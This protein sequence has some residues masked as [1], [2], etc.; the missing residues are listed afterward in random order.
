MILSSLRLPV[1][2]GYRIIEQIYSSKQ[3]LVY[4]AVREADQK[5]V[6]IK[7]MRNE[8]PTSQEIVQFRNQYFLSKN[9]NT[10]TIVKPY[11]LEKYHKSYA[12]VMEDFGGM[13][14][15]KQIKNC[16][17]DNIGDNY[18]FLHNFLDIAI[19][20]TSALDELH[21]NQIIHKDI[22]PDN[23]LIN[24]DTKEVK[25]IDFSISTILP[26]EVQF[27]IN[28]DVLEGTLA[29]ISP[30]QTGRMNK[31]IDYRTDYYSL[32]ITLFELLTGQLPFNNDNP[33]GLI[34]SHISEQPPVEKII[35]LNIPLIISEL[36]CK[37]MEKNPEDRY[38]SS[39]GLKHDLELCQ[40]NLKTNKRIGHFE[41]ATKDISDRFSIPDTLYGRQVE[42]KK[43]LDAFNRVINPPQH[44]LVRE[45]EAR[46]GVELMLVKG[47]SG[48]GKTAVVNEIHK[49]IL[50][51]K[52]YFIKC[53]FNQLQQSIPFLGWIQALNDLIEQLL[54][55][56]NEQIKQWKADILSA[57]GDQAQVM[58]DLIPKL[59]LI[60]GLQPKAAKL[61]GVEAQNRLELLFQKLIRTFAIRKH[62]LVIFLDDL[63]WADAASLNFIRLLMCENSTVNNSPT[64]ENV[65]NIQMPN[66]DIEKRHEYDDA[67]LLIGSYRNNE[68]DST[69][70]L[71]LTIE[72]IKKTNVNISDINLTCLNQSDLAFLISDT[73]KCEVNSVIS[74]TEVV[75][76]KTKGNPFFIHQFIN[77]LYKDKVIKFNYDIG[78]WECDVADVRKSA[79]TDDVVEFMTLQIKKL[80][81]YTQKL[82]KIA[83]CIG[84][85]FDL[86]TLS[87]MSQKSE[88]ATITHLWDSVLQGLVLPVDKKLILSNAENKT[89]ELIIDSEDEKELPLGH[90]NA[91]HFKFIHD[92][93]QQAAYSQIP[94]SEKQKIHL[95]LG[96]KLLEK[97]SAQ[98]W[99]EDIFETANQFNKAL[100]L[101]SLQQERYELA[102]MNLLAGQKAISSTAYQE[103]L[104]YLTTGRKLLALDTWSK[105]YQ[106]SLSLHE[107]LAEVTY[108]TGDFEASEEFVEVVIVKAKTLLEKVKVYEIRIQ[109]YT[110]QN[111]LIEAINIAREVLKLFGVNF[112]EKPNQEDIYKGLE[113]TTAIIGDKT[114]EELAN[115]PSISCE[116]KLAIMRIAS[117]MIPPAYIADQLLFPM[118]I[119][120]QVN[121]TVKYGNG[122][123]SA[124]CYAC[125][126][127]ILNSIM[128]D[129][130]SGDKFGKLALKLVDKLN[131]KD[132]KSKT[133]Y[134]LGSFI[135][136]RKSHIKSTLPVLID[137]YKSGIEVG[138]L[139][140]VGY[141]AKEICKHN[142]FIGQELTLLEK[143]TKA[144][145]SSLESIKQSTT[146]NYC[147]IFL[148]SVIHLQ[149]KNENCYSLSG[150]DCNENQL[151]DAMIEAKDISGLHYL[152]L[153]KFILCYWFGEYQQAKENAE[154]VRLYLAGGAGFVTIP[155][156]YFYESLTVLALSLDQEFEH[157]NLLTLVT[158]N[159]IQLKK[160]AHHAPMNYLH[161][162]YL[163]EAERYRVIG[164]Y[165]EAIDF[166]ERAITIAKENEY[167]H[168]EALANEL[169]AKF[170]LKWGKH[171]I[172]K[173]YL[174]DA[175]YGYINWG[176]KAKV[177]DLQK[178]YPQLLGH[179]F[180]HEDNHVNPDDTN[181]GTKATSISEISRYES[182]SGSNTNI[183]T[184]LDL[185]SV[186][187]ASQA[188]SER[189]KFDELLSTLMEV[190]MENAGASKCALIL[191]KTADFD[192]ELTAIS[193]NH[194]ISSIFTELPSIPLDSSNKVPVRLINYVKRTK[195]TIVIDDANVENILAADS[196][197]L[198][199][200]PKSILCMAI[201]NQGKLFG[202]IYLENKLTSGV[203]TR[204]LI[205]FINLIINQAAIS[206]KN[207]IL[208]NNLVE[209]KED[210][211]NYNQSLEEK[212]A[213]RTQEINDK[214]QRL[215][216]ALKELQNTQ[217]QLIQTEKM[218][219][220][221]Q[222]I[223]GIAHE[224]NN[225]INFIHGNISHANKYV[226]DLLEMIAIYK[227]EFTED[228][229]IVTEKSTE[230]DL[231]FIVEDLPKILNSI[232]VGT[233]RIRDIILGLRNFSRLDEAEMKS[234][235]IHE[236]I[237]NTLMILQ[238]RFKSKDNCPEIQLIKEY[239]HLPEIS[240]YPS[241]LNQVFMNILNNA[242]DALEE[243]QRKV[244][245]TKNPIISIST[246]LIDSN[247]LRISIGDNGFGMEPKVKQKIFDPF[248]TTKPVG[249]G[250]GLGLSISYQIIVKKHK[251]QLICNSKVG[252][253]TKFVIDLPT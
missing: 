72:E 164:K 17:F 186:I 182:I 97:T 253:G 228:N 26:K 180:L 61:S 212:V 82:L 90:R 10:S 195:E 142:Y 193:C 23:I 32:G 237:E 229:C 226:E 174:D 240:C 241:Q 21:R 233:S 248:F 29:Y 40:R 130:E 2:S 197:I 232:E 159:Q 224:I 215:K 68:V 143:Q 71:S 223:A 242:I 85:Q 144:Y 27:L 157:E 98:S 28:P 75:F 207:A 46:K 8:Y 81:S 76:A 102:R 217:S 19:K 12:F 148:Q 218:S 123:L 86:E 166:Y 57:L 51:E 151:L 43:L 209:S 89:A 234:V 196:Y 187:K 39:L 118:I 34:Y 227:Q 96:K 243:S 133:F 147:R 3:T 129:I 30:E 60:I 145:I 177:K 139:D 53:Q 107:A 150:D 169:A 50:Q 155:Y 194:N 162:F 138:T 238:H 114:I 20:I 160:W 4:R 33:L 110:S 132:I 55:E 181:L 179:I 122:R 126:G 44:H 67:L 59:E 99:E 115:L 78:N 31:G 7:M 244:K 100:S 124:F 247:T 74:F 73:L 236:G 216:N 65:M 205:K 184:S 128:H 52:G 69:H 172:A 120:S 116:N 210:L 214:N 38:Q 112:P 95:Q 158:E 239:A 176:A 161:K 49:H 135:I 208:Y 36:I 199:E 146:S 171:K 119:L 165:L 47:Y 230:I 79:L 127:I 6:V 87:K 41:L 201:I 48:T 231:P 1:V 35:N 154:K 134:V 18:Y 121:L 222:M 168:E 42:I 221:G 5:P 103:A 189:I 77:T 235:D 13:T 108:L 9:L 24:P 22:K 80:P 14:V 141:C 125:Y 252:E 25:I 113:E 220:L 64:L 198:R 185:E 156:F 178:C 56:S 183:S 173:A 188:L 92:R 225:P 140:F 54:S 250:T 109:A 163:V 15:N 94:E 63:Q 104:K 58:I 11:S 249:S 84:S 117:S 203:F 219:S 190:I 16:T 66:F 175:Y 170:Y 136:H 105:E 213:Q 192:L 204:K 149:S 88:E 106:L 206:L 101:I 245:I 251:G 45:K 246:K 83:A 62:P 93:L 153:N 111:K 37:L 70:L 91:R 191:S 167:T 131:D 200:Q 137:G 211:E 202:I 152:Y